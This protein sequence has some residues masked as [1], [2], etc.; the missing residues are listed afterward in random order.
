[1]ENFINQINEKKLP[2]QVTELLMAETEKKNINGVWMYRPEQ[3][4]CSLLTIY[5]KDKLLL[6]RTFD[7][8]FIGDTFEQDRVLISI[9]DDADLEQHREDRYLFFQRYARKEDQIYGEEKNYGRFIV[10]ESDLKSLRERY[11]KGEQLL[12]KYTEELIV[13]EQVGATLF[14]LK[15]IQHDLEF[16]EYLR[17]G[18]SFEDFTLTER[19]HQMEAFIPEI[20]KLFLKEGDQYYLL[21]QIENEDM[22]EYMDE[23]LP[24]ISKIKKKMKGFVLQNMRVK[25]PKNNHLKPTVSHQFL[26]DPSI[27]KVLRPLLH[28][29]HLEEVYL[30]H[31]I[32]SIQADFQHHHYYLLALVSKEKVKE[33]RRVSQ[34]INAALPLHLKFTIIYHTR[35]WIQ[36]NLYQSQQFLKTLMNKE[37]QI[38]TNDF[39]PKI[40]WGRDDAYR[41]DD[42]FF[43]HRR[44]KNIYKRHLKGIKRDEKST[45]ASIIPCDLN[46]YFVQILI[47]SLYDTLGYLAEINDVEVLWNLLIYAHPMHTQLEEHLQ[48]LSFDL[49]GYLSMHR[50]DKLPALHLHQDEKKLL[51]GLIQRIKDI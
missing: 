41:C 3:Q 37:H 15:N 33:A 49:I 4:E 48:Q 21:R 24:F 32:T 47:N 29:A 35:L 51:F 45:M 12:M 36:E 43:Y 9:L 8:L 2:K 25:Q 44:A 23:H 14:S 16:L 20:K 39:H 1:M 42:S 40:H 46:E 18:R 19:L 34:K 31:E 6:Q 7:Y 11:E 38:Y 5:C 27:K 10:T 50:K 22:V 13:D 26:K 17:F 28:M 30:F